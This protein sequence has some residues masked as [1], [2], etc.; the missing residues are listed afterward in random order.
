MQT[1]D[2]SDSR[3]DIGDAPDSPDAG[4]PFTLFRVPG[5]EDNLIDNLPEGINQPFD[6]CPAMVGKKILFLPICTACLTPNQD[7]C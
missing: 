5:N 4:K 6:K 3:P 2:R 7:Y 1:P